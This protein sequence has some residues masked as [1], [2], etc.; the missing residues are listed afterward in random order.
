MSQLLQPPILSS[1]FPNPSRPFQATFLRLNPLLL[2]LPFP[3]PP[4]RPTLRLFNNKQ[5]KSL[6][7]LNRRRR[8][9]LNWQRRKSMKLHLKSRT[10][11]LKLHKLPKRML[12]LLVSSQNSRGIISSGTFRLI[13]SVLLVQPPL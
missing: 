1:P 3:L 5:L 6:A 7:R 12:D 13:G 11:S 9:L 4:P 8:K 10:L 2:K